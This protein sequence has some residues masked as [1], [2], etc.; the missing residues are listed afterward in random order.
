MKTKNKMAAAKNQI[1]KFCIRL[2]TSILYKTDEPNTL[3]NLRTE[4]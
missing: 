3:L 1:K 2:E 4:S